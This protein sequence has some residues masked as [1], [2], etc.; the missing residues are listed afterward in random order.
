MSW[1]MKTSRKILLMLRCYNFCPTTITN[2]CN[3]LKVP[4]LSL[5]LL[6]WPVPWSWKRTALKF[7]EICG[8]LAKKYKLEMLEDNQ[9]SQIKSAECKVKVCQMGHD[10]KTCTHHLPYL[11]LAAWPNKRNTDSTTQSRKV[12]WQTWISLATSATTPSRLR[13]L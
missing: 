12:F 11:A 10:Q 4:K 2:S 13:R 9:K 1:W 6:R 7:V 8:T 3:K 5:L